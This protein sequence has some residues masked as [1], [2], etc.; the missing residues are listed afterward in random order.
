MFD[1]KNKSIRV[2]KI[3][4]SFHTFS[5]NLFVSPNLKLCMVSKGAALW[6]ISDRCVSVKEGDIVILN[7]QTK[8]VFREVSI[9]KGIELLVIEFEAQLFMNQFRGLFFGESMEQNNIIS[10]H[11]EIIKIFKEIEVEAENKLLYSEIIIGAKLVEIL[12]LLMRHFNIEEKDSRKMN[13]E[14]YRVL[15][16]IDENYRTDISLQ[17]VAEQMNL[18]ASNLSKIFSKCMGMGFAQYI[19]HKRINYAIHL[20]QSSEKTVLEIALECGFNNV[21]SFYKAFKKIT[22]M[23]PKD[24]RKCEDGGAI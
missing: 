21:A 15:E 2:S 9:S 8:R 24:Y 20:I 14:M 7:N 1:L 4:L 17:K 19:M 13:P 3:K 18:S 23:N 16:Y 10:D 5:R 6:Q 22:N 11:Y 12:S